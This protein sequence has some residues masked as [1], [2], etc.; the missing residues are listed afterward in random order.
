MDKQFFTLYN[1]LK[2]PAI[3]FGTWQIKNDIVKDACLTAL[4]EGYRHIDTAKAY[5]NEKG[6]GESLKE[7]GLTREDVFI[8]S[9]IPAEI[10]DYE[11]AKRCI[12]ES[13]E[14]LDTKYIDLMLIHAPRPWEEMA[15][16]N[17]HR[18]FKENIEV[19]RALEEA[20]EEGLLKSIGVS[21]FDID[22]L[23][24]IIKNNKIKPMVNQICI[25][26][27]CT[28][29]DLID[30]CKNNNILVEA[31]SPLATGRLF[32][33]PLIIDMAKKYNVSIAKLAIRYCYQLDTL[34]LPKSITPSRIKENLDI[35][36]F[37]ISEEDMK[38]LKNISF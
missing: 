6:V 10:K 17:G 2:I 33:K 35:F 30:Y 34:P 20:F 15:N 4:K 5:G 3:G 1:G 26:A 9:K 29:T 14:L 38:I 13:L 27:G 37:E 21:N 16:R 8:T 32:D 23:N 22:D 31:Y 11:D 19:Y 18:Y 36:D 7:C 28:P 25:F 12:R 24:N